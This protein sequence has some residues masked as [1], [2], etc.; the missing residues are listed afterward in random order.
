MTRALLTQVEEMAEK[1]HQ[2]P[3]EARLAMRPEFSRL[4]SDLRIEGISVPRY[5][6]QLETDL[7]EQDAEN[8]FDNMPV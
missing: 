6:Q 8:L 3:A 7:S 1:I 5:L 4:L 2:Q